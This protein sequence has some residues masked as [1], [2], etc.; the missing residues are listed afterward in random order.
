MS[1]SPEGTLD[2]Y[3]SASTA[4]LSAGRSGI[5]PLC[6][7]TTPETSTWSC[8]FSPTPGRFSTTSIPRLRSAFASPTPESIRS[9]G[10]FMEPAG[11]DHFFVGRDI[12][13]GAACHDLDAR[14]TSPFEVQLHHTRV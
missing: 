3:A 13:Y 4:L 7:N 14:A 10:L 5:L 2:R 6:L 12:R 9:L 8:R 1:V 11:K